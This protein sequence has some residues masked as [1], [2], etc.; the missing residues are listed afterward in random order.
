M[1]GNLPSM[2]V[3]SGDTSGTTIILTCSP[4]NIF[5][6]RALMVIRLCLTLSIGYL[7][8]FVNVRFTVEEGATL[9]FDMPITRFGPNSGVR[10]LL[11]ASRSQ[12]LDYTNVHPS[13]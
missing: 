2:R 8:R 7:F 9:V 3:R 12:L 4:H 6:C 13:L 1:T 11:D 10:L 5:S